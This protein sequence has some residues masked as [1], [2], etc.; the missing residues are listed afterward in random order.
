VS[1]PDGPDRAHATASSSGELL[2]RLR[3]GDSQAANRLL[4]RHMPQLY[5]WAHRRIPQWARGI[6][7]TADVVQ[8]TLLHT[9]KRLRWFEP[10]RDGALLGYLRRALLNRV[11]DQ[12]RHVARHPGSAPLDPRHAY[13]GDSPLEQAIKQ[14]SREQYLRA[15]KRL[16]AEDRNVIVARLELG[17][18]YEQLAL[19]V[20]R[21]SPEAA[22]LA[23]RR[24]LLRLAKE[25]ERV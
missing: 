14:Q 6:V 25:M 24:A 20:D 4:A 2:D 8:D 16:R 15:L 23:V 5:R 7:D 10:R 3:A 18:S 13:E 9:Y 19:I 11:R 12:F 22:R 21:P 17:Y 1:R